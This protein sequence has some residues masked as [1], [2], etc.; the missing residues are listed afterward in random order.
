MR[1]AGEANMAVGMTE[2]EFPLRDDLRLTF[3]L[4]ANLT[5][6]EADRLAAFVRSLPK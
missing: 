5:E 4:P 1:P 6:R 2:V 3:Q